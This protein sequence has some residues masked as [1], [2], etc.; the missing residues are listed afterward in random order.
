MLFLAFMLF[1]AAALVMPLAQEI[2]IVRTRTIM[3][4]IVGII[5]LGVVISFALAYVGF[6]NGGLSSA[7]TFGFV[8]ALSTAIF[9]IVLSVMSAMND[10]QMRLH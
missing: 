4:G 2:T 5:V 1:F 8:G 7:L 3:S 9:V 10:A 6:M